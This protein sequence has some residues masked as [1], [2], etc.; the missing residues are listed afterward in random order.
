MP[1]PDQ[2]VRMENSADPLL[3]AGRAVPPL[4][5]QERDA[6]IRIGLEGGKLA[7]HQL[8]R[9]VLAALLRAQVV[10]PASPGMVELT[11]VGVRVLAD[12]AKAVMG[13]A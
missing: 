4:N 8:E 9:A 6:V 10:A 2:E 11:A 3:A 5:D 1:P 12:A 13:D 7:R